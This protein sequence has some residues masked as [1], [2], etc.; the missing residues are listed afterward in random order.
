MSVRAN[1]VGGVCVAL[2]IGTAGSSLGASADQNVTYPQ[3]IIC[4]KSG[5]RYFAYLDRIGSDGVAT[6]ITPSGQ[7]ATISEGRVVR[8]K[9]AA[10]GSCAGKTID[11]LREAGQT[12]SFGD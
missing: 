7:S 8:S 3:I 12:R 5:I 1:I 6:Y 2:L 9:G 4:G 10:A 11:E